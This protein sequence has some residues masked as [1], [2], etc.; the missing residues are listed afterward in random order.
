MALLGNVCKHCGLVYNG[1]NAP[2]FEFHHE[3]PEF[4]EIG[5]TRILTN[6]AWNKVLEEL[7]KCILVCANCHNQHHGG[8]W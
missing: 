7:A 5:I 3:D 8:K 2:V 6:R 1:L 4:K